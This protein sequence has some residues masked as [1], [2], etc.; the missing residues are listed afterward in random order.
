LTPEQRLVASVK[1]EA[2]AELRDQLSKRIS[3]LDSALNAP[4]PKPIQS[5][6]EHL[7]ALQGFATAKSGKCDFLKNG[8]YDLVAAVRSSKDGVRTAKYHFSAS[9]TEPT[10]FR[11]RRNSS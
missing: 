3:D 2:Y 4:E 5:M 10:L 1:R 9:A 8:P 6:E 7:E 11:F